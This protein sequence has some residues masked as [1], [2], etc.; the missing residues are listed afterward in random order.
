[1]ILCWSSFV[2][3]HKKLSVNYFFLNEIRVQVRS[4]KKQNLSIDGPPTLNID[5]FK[6]APWDWTSALHV[7]K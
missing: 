3:P 1:M 5:L 7:P 6:V 4:R 2:W